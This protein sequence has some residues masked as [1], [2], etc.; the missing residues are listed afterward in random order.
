MSASVLIG[1]LAVVG[2]ILLVI[3]QWAS[4][5][6]EYLDAKWPRYLTGGGFMLILISV[7]LFAR[8]ISPGTSL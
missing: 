6:L 4:F 8:F 5:K 7:L 3:S 2:I 1:I